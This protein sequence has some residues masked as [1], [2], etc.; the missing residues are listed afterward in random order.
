MAELE[1]S[2][3]AQSVDPATEVDVDKLDF[4]FVESCSDWKQLYQVLRVLKSGKEGFFPDLER[5]TETKLLN[6]M[7]DK[8][9]KRYL[10]VKSS[11]SPLQIAEAEQELVSWL[12]SAAMIDQQL[13]GASDRANQ[14]IDTCNSE[15]WKMLQS[16]NKNQASKLVSLRK[17][18]R[19]DEMSPIQRER[20]AE[21]ERRKGNESFKAFD[22]S[23]ALSHYSKSLAYLDSSAVVWANRAMA[24][25]KTELFDLAETD[26]SIA[27]L[28]DARYKKARSRRGLARFR[29]G[30][31]REVRCSS[32]ESARHLLSA[33]CDSLLRTSRRHCGCLMTPPTMGRA[34]C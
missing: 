3:L 30:K 13:K 26:C 20:K 8:I 7:P 32:G 25:L 29:Q 15:Y 9:K 31:Y 1:D 34:S 16:L 19:C 28:L 11:A 21:I 24:Y 22:Y 10:A 6:V 12:T 14:Q 23:T 33:G 2:W 4:A 5:V 17:E 18:L 27:L